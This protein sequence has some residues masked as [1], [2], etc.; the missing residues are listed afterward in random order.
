MVARIIDGKARAERL[1]GDVRAAV[2]ERV[3]AGKS[4][5]GL[6]VV[7]VGA[8]PASQIYV[9]NKRKT[10]ESVGMRSFAHDLPVETAEAELLALLAEHDPFEVRVE[11][12][13]SA[14]HAVRLHDAAQGHG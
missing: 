9:R 6:A 14:V 1:T 11:R 12:V 4:P 10:T 7:L 3:A 8:N 13:A 5:P 2:A